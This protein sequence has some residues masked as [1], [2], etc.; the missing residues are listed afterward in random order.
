MPPPHQVIT[1]IKGIHNIYP[2]NDEED[3][4]HK[5]AKC[6]CHGEGSNHEGNNPE[7]ETQ[8]HEKTK[9]QSTSHH[10]PNTIE[11]DVVVVSGSHSAWRKFKKNESH[12][13]RAEHKV[14]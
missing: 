3:H 6:S 9:T 14:C 8:Q 12:Q 1:L 2:I 5:R 7:L 4:G 13:K 10:V 11:E